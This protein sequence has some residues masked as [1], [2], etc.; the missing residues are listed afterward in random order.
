[1]VL[2][3]GRS[4]IG[5][6]D[7]LVVSDDLSLRIIANALID[8]LV[9]GSWFCEEESLAIRDQFPSREILFKKGTAEVANREE[10]L[11]NR[12]LSR[13]RNFS[14]SFRSGIIGNLPGN[15]AMKKNSL[16]P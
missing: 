2:T 12:N 11:F 3:H 13:H 9:P 8:R 7:G 10:Y 14:G 6:G 4:M 16:L 1:M 5:T 15:T